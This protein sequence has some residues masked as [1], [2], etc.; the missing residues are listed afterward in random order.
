[1]SIIKI[2]LTLPYPAV[3]GLFGLVPSPY[4]PGGL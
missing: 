1:M 4:E 2:H 3:L